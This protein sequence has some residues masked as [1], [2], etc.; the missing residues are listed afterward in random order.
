MHS[1]KAAAA[2]LEIDLEQSDV[3]AVFGDAKGFAVS[4]VQESRQTGMQGRV[5]KP[6]MKWRQMKHH[7][8]KLERRTNCLK[9][10]LVGCRYVVVDLQTIAQRAEIV[11]GQI[12][13]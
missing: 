9:L 13:R 1:T 8:T 2:D 4:S 7:L 10:E 12:R 11:V 3:G 5:L 6:Y